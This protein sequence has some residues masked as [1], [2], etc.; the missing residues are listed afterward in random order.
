MIRRYFSFKFFVTIFLLLLT[1]CCFAQ[2]DTR[3]NREFFPQS[4]EEFV[5][6]FGTWLNANT[7][8]G[9][10]G[11]GKTDDTRALQAAFDAVAQGNRCSTL[12]LPAGV[13]L[14]KKTLTIN[15]HINVSVIGQN[16]AT[17]II[18]WNGAA[19]GTML[20]VNGTA[21]SRFNRLT[22]N[23]NQM[24]DVA[25]EQSWDGSKP[26]FDTGNEY[27]EDVFV[28][29]NFGIHG[30]HL[31]HGFAETS[32]LGDR[33]IRIK[34]AG[35]S[36]GN[37]NALDI[38]IRNCLF[39]DCAMGI[40]NIYGAGNFK[41]YNNIFLSS[42]GPDISINNTGEFSIRGNF[43]IHSGKFF[44]AGYSRNPAAIII[45]GNTVLD[46]I[47]TQAVTVGNQGPVI[48]I[49]NFFRSA[50]PTKSGPV[51]IFNGSNNPDLYCSDN[52]FTVSQPVAAKG[53][54][55]VY[56][57]KIVSPLGI[58]GIKTPTIPIIEPTDN[59]VV[60]EVPRSASTDA[61]QAIINKAS[62]LS[63]TR[64]IVHFPFGNFNLTKT[65]I[66]PSGSDMQL[67]GDGFGDQHATTLSRVG[68]TTG[69][70]IL[71]SGPSKATFRDLTIKGNSTCI[72]ILITNVD[73]KG[74]QIILQEFQQ[75]GGMAGIVT[76]RLDHTLVKGFDVELSD[77]EKA[78]SVT[79]GP[80]A[81]AGK[82]AEGKIIIY[83]GAESD[84][85]LSHEVLNG[86]NLIVQDTW[87]EGKIK[88]VYAKLSGNGTFIATGD[89]IATPRLSDTPSIIFDSFYGRALFCGDDLSGRILITGNSE[90]AKILVLGILSEDEAFIF[91]TSKPKGDVRLFLSRSRN[92]NSKIFSGGSYPLTDIASK[93]PIF[94]KNIL[95][96]MPSI[97]KM[98]SITKANGI[99]EVRFYRVMSING[100]TGLKIEA[101]NK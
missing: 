97:P 94:I 55:L 78:I 21:Y 11:D 26:H 17:T 39:E 36:L 77:L 96:L 66:I 53:N 101:G 40:T 33:F 38:W 69:P 56:N 10:K 61:I 7:D 2:L 79:G 68:N 19:Y 87:Y 8:F 47:N 80:L 67:T 98:K 74:S 12:Y 29:V 58:Q 23:G 91:N 57:E 49:N 81:N 24:A 30:G 71:I 13:Y 64:P 90:K 25:I 37:F 1:S 14:I 92:Y 89:H 48:F 3:I 32:I 100:T 88:S 5:G 34:K 35:V 18:K 60:F 9:A 31:G 85:R 16:P 86:G 20:Q 22:L 42:S 70:I 28:D 44:D 82:P 27:A 59:R 84:N 99:T 41:V 50:L 65:L 76:S 75:K 73:Q 51:A 4:D 93:D 72:N 54:I 62:N 46:P 15:Y 43:S 52:T 63:G 6:P 45:E 95:S 83:S